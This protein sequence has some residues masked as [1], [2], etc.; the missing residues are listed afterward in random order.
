MVNT[1]PRTAILR[2]I[3][4]L[5][6]PPPPPRLLPA[7]PLPPAYPLLPAP[8]VT[9]LLPP[10]TLVKY[11]DPTIPGATWQ[12]IEFVRWTDHYLVL[13]RAGRDWRLSRQKVKDWLN[14]HLDILRVSGDKPDWAVSIAQEIDELLREIKAAIRERPAGRVTLSRGYVLHINPDQWAVLLGHE[15]IESYQWVHVG[16]PGFTD[17]VRRRPVWEFVRKVNRA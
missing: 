12:V 13:R 10:G 6:N 8:P 2:A 16:L 7:G 1:I 3:R 5:E 4:F 11:K 9:A 14:P 17:T 15:R